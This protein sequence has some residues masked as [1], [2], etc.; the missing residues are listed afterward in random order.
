MKKLP[1][2]LVALLILLAAC[3]TPAA[4][5]ASGQG[6]VSAAPVQ[7]LPLAG[8]GEGDEPSY[9][10][11]FRL[12]SCVFAPVCALS[13]ED[14]RHYLNATVTYTADSAGNTL[15]ES[16]D[17]PGYQEQ[18]VTAEDFSAG[19]SG[20][21]ALEDVNLSGQQVTSV[22]LADTGMFGCFFYVRGA[23]SLVIPLDGAFF[24][25]QRV[26]P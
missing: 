25:A 16:C 3:A 22:T 20:A 9:Y 18:T 14:A 17:A 1:Y 8:D 23:D 26:Q 24:L 4:P 13:M 21:L 12:T 19:Y 10:G 15:G 7:T 6:D 2:L 11:T 5:D